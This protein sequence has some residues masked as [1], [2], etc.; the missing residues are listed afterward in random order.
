[1]VKKD[2]ISI[3]DFSREELIHILDKAKELSA[4]SE[5]H[6]YLQGKILGTVFYE[7][8]TRTKISFNVAMKRLGGNVIGFSHIKNSSFIKGESFYDT[9]KILEGYCDIIALRAPWEGAARYAGEI[10]SVPV[11]NAGDGANQ[12]PSQTLLDLYTIRETQGRLDSLNIGI[13]GDLKYGRTVHSLLMALAHFDCK[14]SMFSPPSLRVPSRF[15]KFL[16]EGN[17]EFQEFEDYKDSVN[18]LDILYVSRVQKERFGDEREY[19]KVSNAYHLKKA[20]ILDVKSNFRILH[21]LPRV[22]EIN[23]NVD[24]TE[25]AAYFQQARNGVTV[26]EALIYLLLMR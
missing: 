24:S 22:D 15:K 20:D 4:D 8:S 21:P 2:I 26:R 3:R 12:H 10:V 11:I 9:M 17:I 23:Q 7:T 19:K 1:M 16:S 14:I 25:H 5:K 13:M 18:D 6:T